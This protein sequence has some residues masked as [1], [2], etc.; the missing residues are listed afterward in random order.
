VARR[1]G[2][3]ALAAVAVTLSASAGVADRPRIAM[4]GAG[5][6][7][8]RATAAEALLAG[9]AVDAPMIAEAAAAVAANA[10]PDAD[11]KASSAYRRHL[12]AALAKRAIAA[13]WR[14]AQAHGRDL[15]ARA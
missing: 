8:L 10:R 4:I 9:R 1:K 14:R 5:D 12:L 6:T 3:F 11:L 15:P 13:A 7:P 2:D